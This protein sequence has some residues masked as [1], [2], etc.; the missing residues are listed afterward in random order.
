MHLHDAA[1]N[2]SVTCAI[3]LRGESGDSHNSPGHVPL[4]RHVRHESYK[5]SAACGREIFLHNYINEA[6][7]IRFARVSIY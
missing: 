1:N 6:S 2:N 7:I 5:G 3:I 4:N